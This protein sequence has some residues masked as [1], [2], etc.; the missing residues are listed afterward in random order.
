MGVTVGGERGAGS[1]ERG[2]KIPLSAAL[3]PHPVYWG[4]VKIRAHRMLVKKGSGL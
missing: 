1:G 3:H 4:I 2:R